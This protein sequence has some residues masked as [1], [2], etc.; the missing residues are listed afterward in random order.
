MDV[1]RAADEN[2]KWKKRLKKILRSVWKNGFRH[3]AQ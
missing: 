3:G 1:S 2:G